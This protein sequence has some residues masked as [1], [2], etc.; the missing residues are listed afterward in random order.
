MVVDHPERGMQPGG[1]LGKERWWDQRK[2]DVMME[3]EAT[4]MQLEGREKGQETGTGGQGDFC[5]ELAGRSTLGGAL[6]LDG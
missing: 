1:S 3:A 6:V 2:E 5:P 4:V